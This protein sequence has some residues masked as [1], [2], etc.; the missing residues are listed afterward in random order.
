V[1][2]A[3][4]EP[5]PRISTGALAAIHQG[6][7][8]AFS[9]GDRHVGGTTVA[10]L[11]V[12]AGILACVLA[13]ESLTDARH[14]KPF[15]ERGVDMDWWSRLISRS[16]TGAA[17]EVIATA[18][19]VFTAPLSLAGRASGTSG[20]RTHAPAS[21]VRGRAAPPVVLVHGFAASQM[22]W[23]A[24]R[25]ALR[26]AGWT[27]VSFNYSPWA[28]SVDELADRL[29]EFVEDLRAVTGAGKVHLVGHSLG[30]L[31][32][33]QALTRRRLAGRV[34]LVVTLASP[35]GGSPWAGLLPLGPLV[36]ALR[37]GAPLL[38]HLAGAPP[39][40]GVRW[41]AFGATLDPIVPA[42][43]AVPANRPATCV[44]LDAAGHSGMLLDPNVIA[45]IVAAVTG[46]DARAGP[47]DLLAG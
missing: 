8:R 47:G 18:A 16:A 12:G 21:D 2:P 32:I 22:C 43:R 20:P 30:G 38:R 10:Q 13:A 24:L 1:T 37:P 42:D 27:V 25:R 40:A 35:F 7:A 33:A 11:M 23:F 45:R 6:G 44:T 4:E 5:S 15:S 41:L 26:S 19:A 39:P 28:S 36:R 29:T 31:I 34:D 46:P 17:Y 3:T 9:W 14:Q